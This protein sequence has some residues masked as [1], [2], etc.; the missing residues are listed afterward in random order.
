MRKRF[1]ELDLTYPTCIAFLPEN[2]EH[3]SDRAELHR[4]TE[5]ITL[6][7]LF[8]EQERVVSDIYETNNSP[9]YRFEHSISELIPTIFIS[10]AYKREN[11]DAISMMRNAIRQSGYEPFIVDDRAFDGLID[12]AIVAGIRSARFVVADLTHGKTG[13]RGS[14]YYEAGLA[15]GQEKSVILTA[16]QD[17]IA[18]QKIAFDLDHYPIISWT[19]EDLPKFSKELQ[20]RIEALYGQGP[21]V[22]KA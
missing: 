12:D 11:P 15:R 18:D 7:K 14:V 5:A 1:I 2:I 6:T 4:S 16:R 8:K 19:T 17:H 20:S 21:G 9:H 3:A 13:M 22:N 10:A